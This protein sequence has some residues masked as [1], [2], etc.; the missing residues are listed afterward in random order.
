MRVVCTMVDLLKPKA[1]AQRGSILPERPKI[2]EDLQRQW[3]LA[4]S[5][6]EVQR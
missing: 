6:R 2:R 4:D 3:K 5:F 1:W